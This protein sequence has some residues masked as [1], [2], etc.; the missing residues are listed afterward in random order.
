MLNQRSGKRFLLNPKF[1]INFI[2]TTVFFNILLSCVFFFAAHQSFSSF[3]SQGRSAGIPSSHVFFQ[4]INKQETNF[5][6]NMG[7]SA[8]VITIIACIYG[9][10]KSHKIAGPMYRLNVEFDRMKKNKSLHKFNFR[11]KD[12]FQEIPEAFNSALDDIQK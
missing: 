11:Q 2:L 8:I 7:I 1:Q 6:F 5:Y 3:K 12:F 9:V 4:F 10:M